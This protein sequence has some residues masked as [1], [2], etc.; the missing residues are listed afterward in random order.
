MRDDDKEVFL[1]I[2]VSEVDAL[3]PMLC[4][5]DS[6]KKWNAV[7]YIEEMILKINTECGLNN[8]PFT[9]FQTLYL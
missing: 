3:I 7:I 2:D 8:C 6:M 9:E 4:G 1:E 5:K